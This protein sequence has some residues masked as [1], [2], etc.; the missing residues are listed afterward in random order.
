MRRLNHD[1]GAIALIVA[2]LLPVLVGVSA[3]VL[4]VGGIYAE[5]AQLQN[6]ADA[7]ALAIAADCARGSCGAPATTAA[8]L[9]NANA[10]D[11]AADVAV[12]ISGA[13][14]T[15]TASTRTASGS[16]RLAHMFADALGRMT[17]GEAHGGS[18]VQA[19]ASADWGSPGRATTTP[20]A[21]S[22]CEW[23]ALAGDVS[24][25]PTAAKTVFFH[26]T[27]GKVTGCTGPA[28][29]VTPGGWGWLAPAASEC[30]ADVRTG[31]AVAR[32]GNSV[33]SVCTAGYWSSRIGQTLMLPVF[34]A[35][36]ADGTFRIEGFAALKLEAYRLSGDP[37]FNGGSSS[38]SGD[39]RCIRGR[40]IDYVDLTGAPELGGPNYGAAAV[41]LD[42]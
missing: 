31:N 18:T 28:G 21:F 25:L 11:D 14:V 33:P 8:S 6:G 41:R 10:N 17:T 13:T 26:G 36:N 22:F 1:D 12:A 19:R 3:L 34:S 5:K 39:D 38:C 27:S 32:S 23:Q 30:S 15:V 37:A 29:Q 24:M 16:N 4:D 9:A 20:L 7:A 2:M 40:F 35:I 42:S